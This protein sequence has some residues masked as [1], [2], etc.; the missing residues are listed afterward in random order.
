MEFNEQGAELYS[1]GTK[2]MVL[3]SRSLPLIHKDM[4]IKSKC[5]YLFIFKKS[6]LQ[7]TTGAIGEA[8][9]GHGEQEARE[10]RSPPSV[11]LEVGREKPKE[12][13]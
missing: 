11:R 4:S 12:M 8:E 1:K 2:K 10:E 7:S 5:I 6:T 9:A 13:S 3:P